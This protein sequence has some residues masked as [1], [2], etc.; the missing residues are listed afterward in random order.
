MV[1]QSNTGLAFQDGV[2][3]RKN[4]CAWWNQAFGPLQI[5]KTGGLLAYEPSESIVG[6]D[7]DMNGL[8][9]DDSP[10][11]QQTAPAEGGETDADD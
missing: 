3:I 2:T 5:H 4:F 11:E 10:F 6:I 9:I 1:Q 8:D 7:M